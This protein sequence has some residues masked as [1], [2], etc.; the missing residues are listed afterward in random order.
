MPK[1]SL[2]IFKRISNNVYHYLTPNVRIRTKKYSPYQLGVTS[3]AD[4]DPYAQGILGVAI[5]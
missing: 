5:K 2:G 4:V 1:L 3:H